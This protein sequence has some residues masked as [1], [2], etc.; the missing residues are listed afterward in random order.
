MRK[1]EWKEEE[2]SEKQTEGAMQFILHQEL[3]YCP[4]VKIALD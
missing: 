2:K 1:K 4:S 3:S